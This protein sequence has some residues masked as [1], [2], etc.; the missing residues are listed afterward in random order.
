M[1]NAQSETIC[2]LSMDLIEGLDIHPF[3]QF[4]WKGEDKRLLWEG[5]AKIA[6]TL[7]DRAEYEMVKQ[8]HRK[9][10]TLHISPRNYDKMFEQIA[11][12]GLVWFPIQRTK[13]YSGFSHKHFPVE[14]IDLNASVYGVLARSVEDAETFREASGYYGGKTD[15]TVIGELLGFPECCME[16]F[17]GVWAAGYY[18]PVWQAALSTPGAEKL[19]DT[20]IR[21]TGSVHS[22]ALLR[23]AGF[24]T[25][26]HLPCSL[27][28]EESQ[29]VGETWLKVMY[30]IDPLGTD[31]LLD[32]LKLPVTWSCYRGIAIITTDAFMVSTNSMP[33]KN[34]YVI[35]F[36]AV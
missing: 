32:V 30:N 11:R 26:S 9:C 1:D 20:H 5:K 2:D 36:V 34:E 28:C 23:Y 22:H 29:A 7:H 18:D 31:A 12:D 3:T 19:S 25:T 33:T 14:E 4:I 27:A 6:R 24:R 15:H 35:E 16:F 13:N 8:G 10:A 21:V 17:N